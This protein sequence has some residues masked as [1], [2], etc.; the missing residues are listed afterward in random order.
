MSLSHLVYMSRHGVRSPYPPVGG[1]FSL[2]S[3][4]PFPSPSDWGMTQ[5]AYDKQYLTGHGE[6]LVP[7]MGRF[8]RENYQNTALFDQGE[9][10]GGCPTTLTVFADNSTRDVQTA[11]LFM[12]GF[13]HDCDTEII[14]A[15]SP[16]MAPVLSD[17]YN[18]SCPS[19]SQAQMNGSF[20]GDFNALSTLYLPLIN[21]ISDVLNIK[22]VPPAESICKYEDPSFAGDTCTLSKLGY[23][24]TG[25]YWQG[26]ALSPLYYASQFAEM[27]ML[28][29]VGNVTNW[30]FGEM[31]YTQLTQLYQLHTQVMAFGTNWWNAQRNGAQT[32][33]Y[34]LMTMEQSINGEPIDGLYPGTVKDKIT[35]LFN[36][37]T[38]LLYLR[39]LLSVEWLVKAFDLNVASTAG[40]LGFELW[41]DHNNRRYVRVYY[42]AARPDQQRNAELLSSA[43]PPSIAYLIIKQC[44]DYFCPYAKFRAIVLDIIDTRCLEMPLKGSIENLNAMLSSS[45]G[46]CDD[47]DES[48]WKTTTIVVGVLGG[49]LVL[50]AVGWCVY[51]LYRGSDSVRTRYASVASSHGL[52]DDERGQEMSE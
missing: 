17:H 24:Y 15:T 34:I 26:M 33:G 11:K 8:W 14:V 4:K 12:Q 6:K 45:A 49:T 31:S 18:T 37:D 39:E 41:K 20:G 28:Q 46:S 40:A 16:L 47:D 32:L 38:N 42:T 3:R 23:R 52:Q 48:Q 44:G 7:L 36:H 5:E 2:Y 50:L 35:L 19:A 22:Q 25:E 27:F 51:R 30:G 21:A 29:Y 9:G 13:L 43:N 10:L 1:N